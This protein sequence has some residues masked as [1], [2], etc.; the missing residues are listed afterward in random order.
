M[1]PRLAES[2]PGTEPLNGC[3]RRISL[4]DSVRGLS[5]LGILLLNISGFGLPSAA[6]LNPAYAG[7]PPLIDGVV[8][9]LLDVF[10]QGVFLSM[11]AILFGG[12]LRLL[13]SRGRSWNVQRLF[14][15]GVLGVIHS[16][17]LWDGDILLS[18]SIAG[19]AAVILIHG[20][21][22]GENLMRTGGLLYLIG[23]GVLVWLGSLSSAQTNSGWVPSFSELQAEAGWK[24]VG[25]MAAWSV[26]FDTM[27]MSQMSMIIQYGWELVGSMLIGSA[28]MRSGWLKGQGEPQAYRRQ[29]WMLFGASLAIGVPVVGLN[30]WTGWDY[31]WGSYYLQAPKDLSASLQGL[32]YIALW[33]GYGCRIQ[34]SRIAGYLAKVGRMTLSNYLLQ[35]LICTTLFYRLGWYQQLDRLSLLALVPVIWCVN[36]LFSVVWLRRF[37]SGPVEWLWRRLSGKPPTG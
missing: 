7:P 18:Y 3:S 36:I 11:F 19:L 1:Q 35:T 37:N 16:V 28:L 29:G 12:A 4:L 21:S 31:T 15:L 10:A 20:A 26:R 6:Y 9:T 34:S 14:W 8:W 2:A 25:G 13:Q 5:L 27:L 24:L 23:L 17:L 33:Y 30:W 32:G 22:S